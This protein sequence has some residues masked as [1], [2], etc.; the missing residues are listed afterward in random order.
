LPAEG[1]VELYFN[2][3]KVECDYSADIQ[4]NGSL[5]ALFHQVAT[6]CHATRAERASA[7]STVTQLYTVQVGALRNEANANRLAAEIDALELGTHGFIEFGGFPANNA[8]AHVISE[9][10]VYR[11]WVGAFLDRRE[12]EAV[13]AALGEG[14]Y[15]RSLPAA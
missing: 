11:V 15:V 7:M 13:A 1:S 14:A 10:A 5:P 8:T 2:T 3:G 4:W 9:G 6:A 12:A